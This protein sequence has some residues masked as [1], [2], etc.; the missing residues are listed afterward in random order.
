M[1]F[2]PILHRVVMAR[3]SFRGARKIQSALGRRSVAFVAI[4][5]DLHQIYCTYKKWFGK[6]IFVSTFK[7]ATQLPAPH[8]DSH[9]DALA[10]VATSR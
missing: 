5:L 8:P 7:P 2:S 10:Q 6:N 3:E 9:F 1:V 4:E